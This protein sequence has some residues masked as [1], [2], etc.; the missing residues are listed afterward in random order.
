MDQ[1]SVTPPE[2]AL[3]NGEPLGILTIKGLQSWIDDDIDFSSQYDQFGFTVDGRPRYR[4]IYLRDATKTHYILVDQ[5]PTENAF[6]VRL[7]HI[8]PGLFRHHQEFGDGRKLCFD[9]DYRLTLI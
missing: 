9:R 2:L 1:I 4:C 8:W 6:N 7:L 5:G 3:L